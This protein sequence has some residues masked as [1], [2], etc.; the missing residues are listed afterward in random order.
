MEPEA[1]SAPHVEHVYDQGDLLAIIIRADFREPGIHFVSPPELS[2]QVAYMSHRA[3][4][5]I[6]PHRHNRVRREVNFTQEVLI[7]RRGRLRV[8]FYTDAEIYLRSYE[9]G[10]G[11][12]ILLCSGAHGF[13]VLEELEMIEV[14]QG[15]F[16]GDS[17]KTR[18]AGRRTVEP[19]P[20][21]I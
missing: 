7:I 4:H 14:K 12:T 13:E 5:Q 21:L 20:T 10:A 15:P 6:M 9:L 17:D 1:V 3:G 8:D 11:D 16:S 19:A 2:Q 18:F